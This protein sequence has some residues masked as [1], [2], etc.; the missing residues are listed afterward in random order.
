MIHLYKSK[1]K[2]TLEAV[3]DAQG[4]IHYEFIPEGCTVDKEIM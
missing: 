3:F 1:G 4:L 2:V